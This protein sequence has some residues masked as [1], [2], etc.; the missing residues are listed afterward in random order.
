MTEDDSKPGHGACEGRV[1]RA[2]VT[3]IRKIATPPERAV[4][5][6]IRAGG[7]LPGTAIM[8]RVDAPPATVRAA[9]AELREHGVV[10]TREG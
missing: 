7:P 2:I 4:F 9:L 3:L 6:A 8:V 1:P 5:V 10:E